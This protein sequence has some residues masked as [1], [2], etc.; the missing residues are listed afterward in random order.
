[1]SHSHGQSGI[2]V[3]FKP[4]TSSKNVHQ[5]P[6]IIYIYVLAE[7]GKTGF[8]NHWTTV[9]F[10]LVPVLLPYTVVRVIRCPSSSLLSNFHLLRCSVPGMHTVTFFWP[11]IMCF[12]SV[13]AGFGL[14]EW[15][16]PLCS[17]L[18][19]LSRHSV[20][21]L[22]SLSSSYAA[23]NYTPRFYGS[24]KEGTCQHHQTRWPQN[25]NNTWVLTQSLIGQFFWSVL[26]KTRL[27]SERPVY[28]LPYF[29]NGWALSGAFEFM[30][31]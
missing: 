3:S 4:Y 9:S 25:T 1:M 15:D 7:I 14:Q 30:H 19:S 24:F 5:K 26:G 17:S 21:D 20:M 12:D 28:V 23:R 27:E 18:S 22:R 31:G 29:V 6:I 2:N 8:M 10:K 16:Q 11:G 13:R